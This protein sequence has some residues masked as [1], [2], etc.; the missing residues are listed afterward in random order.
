[1]SFWKP[2][3]SGNESHLSI[4]PIPVENHKASLSASVNIEELLAFSIDHYDSILQQLFCAM[5]TLHPDNMVVRSIFDT[6]SLLPTDLRSD[7]LRLQIIYKELEALINS[8]VRRMCL[9]QRNLIAEDCEVWF[10]Q[11]FMIC[12]GEWFLLQWFDALTRNVENAGKES[13]PIGVMRWA[14]RF[15]ALLRK[16]KSSDLHHTCNGCLHLLKKREQ[17]EEK[18]RVFEM[19]ISSAS[20]ADFELSFEIS[21]LEELQP[22]CSLVKMVRILAIGGSA[23]M[24]RYSIPISVAGVLF[25]AMLDTVPKWITK[26][27]KD[28]PEEKTLMIFGNDIKDPFL[29]R[30]LMFLMSS[31]CDQQCYTT[32]LEHITS[33]LVSNTSNTRQVLKSDDWPRWI[34]QVLTSGSSEISG[35]ARLGIIGGGSEESESKHELDDH[36]KMRSLSRIERKRSWRRALNDTG[37]KYKFQLEINILSKLL[38]MAIISEDRCE[39]LR[40]WFEEIAESLLSSDDLTRVV[41]LATLSS[42]SSDSHIRDSNILSP[43]YKNI[44]EFFDVV[45]HFIFFSSAYSTTLQRSQTCQSIILHVAEDTELPDKLLTGQALLVLDKLLQNPCFDSS[46]ASREIDISQKEKSRNRKITENVKRNLLVCKEFFEAS[47]SFF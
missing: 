42:F 22:H 32:C 23:G 1:M 5:H 10:F 16:A 17:L 21:A 12:H 38:T 36:S 40:S 43:M 27:D 44:V 28:T 41:Y 24:L 13:L 35:L 15:G 46:I 9:C 3:K 4:A 8:D 31:N 34:M 37:Q 29:L 30:L 19:S 45:V 14:L 47:H 25:E 7:F 2:R 20:I 11:S 18:S 26:K 33:L 6:G 39:L